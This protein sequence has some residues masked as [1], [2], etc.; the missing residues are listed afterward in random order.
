[1]ERSG[2]PGEGGEGEGEREGEGEGE[3][4]GDKRRGWGALV[5]LMD[6]RWGME[7]K[8]EEEESCGF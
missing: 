7:E 5:R 2:D 4:G 3:V 6:W 1:V 8:G